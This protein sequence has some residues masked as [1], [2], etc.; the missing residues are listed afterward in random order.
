MKQGLE[1]LKKRSEF[2]TELFAEI[3]LKYQIEIP[4][5][6]RIFLMSY[7]IKNIQ[8][9]YFFIEGKG[10]YPFTSYKHRKS[11]IDFVDFIP[12]KD[13]FHI[14]ED[15]EDEELISKGMVPIGVSG[16]YSHGGGIVLGTLDDSKEKI[17][18]DTEKYNSQNRFL[19]ISQNIFEFVNEI[20]A[21]PIPE[22]N[23][24]YN[25]NPSN[26]YKNW[27]EDFY[28]IKE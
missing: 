3:V 14:Y 2:D 10:L 19:L 27:G 4:F 15:E 18:L 1:L 5:L 7:D 25:I 17:F 11:Q 21:F 16:K 9:E 23:I 20:E 8:R 28:R 13:S 24:S 22:D 26:L 6:Y 12:L